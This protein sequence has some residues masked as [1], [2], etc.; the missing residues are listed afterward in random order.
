MVRRHGVIRR[1]KVRNTL[2]SGAGAN[3]TNDRG[4]VQTTAFA[5]NS[6]YYNNNFLLRYQEYVNLYETSWEARKIIDIPVDDA[7]RQPTIREGLSDEDNKLIDEAWQKYGVERQLRRCMKQER[8]LGGSALL[9]IMML[10]DGERLDEPLNDA[11][12]EKGDLLALNV[13][14][15]AKMSRS[16]TQFDPFSADYD[17][18]DSICIDGIDVDASRMV[19]FDGNAL[20][21]RNSQRLMQRM[22]YNPLGFGESK[23]APLWDILMRSLGTQQGAYQLVNTASSIVMSVNGLRQLKATDNAAEDKLREIVQQ[24]SIYNAALID[25]KDV[26]IDTKTTSFG[27]VPEL[28]MTFTQFLAAASDIPIARFMGSGST[29]LSNTGEGDSRN[30]YDMVDSIR[31]NTRKPAEQRVID[32]IGYSTYGYEEWKRRSKDLVLSYEPLWNL[33]AVQQATR[34]EIVVRTIVSMYQA[35]LISAQ[36]AID[37]LNKRELFETQMEAEEAIMETGLDDSGLFGGDDA[38]AIDRPGENFPT[39]SQTTIA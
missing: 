32:W 34:D 24:L 33:D 10:Q 5:S 18:I 12:M 39:A 36:T 2:V 9:A 27:S 22:R 15:L 7:M 13:I 30:Y 16:R 25:G 8:L 20:F 29:G 17:V 14:D 35:Q 4:A 1:A 26:N 3:T 31:N 19:I 23:L 28:V 6:P 11:N 21:G 37:E 38:V